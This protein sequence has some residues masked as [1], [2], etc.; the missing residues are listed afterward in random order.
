MTKG[1]S[2][3]ANLFGVLDDLGLPAIDEVVPM[4]AEVASDLGLPTPDNVFGNIKGGI[5]S[6]AQ[7]LRPGR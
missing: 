5:R 4:P 3:L 1:N 6:K 2:R 7:G